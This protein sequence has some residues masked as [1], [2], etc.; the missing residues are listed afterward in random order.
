MPYYVYII[1]SR[2]KRL[3]IG[4]TNDLERRMLEHKM[5]ALQGFASRYNIASPVYYETSEGARPAIEREK[6][7]EG[8]LRRKKVALIE[9]VNPEWDDLSESWY[10]GKRDPSLRSG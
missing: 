2:T 9:S 5:G 3:Y 6:Q 4:V 8:W 7:L 10:S 1:A